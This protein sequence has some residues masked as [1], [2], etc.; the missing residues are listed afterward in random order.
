MAKIPDPFSGID[1]G[2]C[3]CNGD[4]ADGRSG[5]GGISKECLRQKEELCKPMLE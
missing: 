4:G 3:S 5:A 2:S 1:G